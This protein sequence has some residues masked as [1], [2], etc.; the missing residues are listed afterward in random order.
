MENSS[1]HFLAVTSPPNGEQGAMRASRLR[2]THAA[3]E[4][5]EW[6][7]VGCFISCDYWELTTPTRRISTHISSSTTVVIPGVAEGYVTTVAENIRGAYP[8]SI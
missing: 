8:Q 3:V 5:K 2:V 6:L 7:S 4:V 1:T